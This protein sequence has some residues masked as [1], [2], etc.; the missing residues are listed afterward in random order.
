MI[1][2]SPEV[3]TSD[4]PTPRLSTR[5]WMIASR[6]LQAVRVDGAG[7]GGVL[8]VRV[9]VVPPRRSRPSLG[10]QVLLIAIRPNRPAT[11]TAKG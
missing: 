5:L 8:A 4:S 6:Q 1:W 11:M 2:L 3:V 7:A 10:V 9:M